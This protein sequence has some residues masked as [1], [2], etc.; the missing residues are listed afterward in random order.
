MTASQ[1]TGLLF[2]FV[3]VL[4]ISSSTL[5]RNPTPDQ[6]KHVAG[7]N[8]HDKLLDELRGISDISGS[9]LGG[10][11]VGIMHNET[12]RRIVS[13]G[14]RIIPRLIDEIE[15]GDHL[16]ACI[17]SLFCLR[18]L[19]ASEAKNS[20]LTLRSNVEIDAR[21]SPKHVNRDM[22]LEMQIKFYLDAIAVNANKNNAPN[23]DPQTKH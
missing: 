15:N 6:S 3:A 14:E 5:I 18:E 12:T 16:A 20:V 23:I 4:A 21:F 2:V 17:Y 9:S 1:K 7:V 22:T 8:Y 11:Y 13:E 19:K 10:P